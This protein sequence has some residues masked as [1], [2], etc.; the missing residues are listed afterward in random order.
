MKGLKKACSTIL[1]IFLLMQL[2]AAGPVFAAVNPV[3]PAP[4]KLSVRAIHN[5]PPNDIQPPIGFN[6]KEGGASGYYADLGWDLLKSPN[7]TP[8]GLSKYINIYVQ[9]VTKPYKAAKTL[10]KRERDLPGDTVSLRM[11]NLNSGTI[12]FM[13]AKAYYTYLDGTT[14]YTSSESASSNTVKVLTDI[15]INAFSF[16][17]SQIK[18]E[19]DD[20]W[21]TGRRIDYKLYV[22]DN[23]SFANTM[24]I[25]ISKEQIGPNG[26]V[27]VNNTTGKLEYVHTVNDPAK[28]YYVK[29]EPDVSDSAL[30]MTPASS[31]VMV[32]SFILAKTTKMSETDAGTIWRLDWSPVITGLNNM[33]VEVSYQIDKYI[34]DVPIPMLMEDG[35]STFISIPPGGESN[36]YIIRANV[37]KDGKPLY[38]SN[39]KIM[40]DRIVV[41]D[42]EVSSYPPTPE[43]IDEVGDSHGGPPI[44]SYADKYDA[45][46]LLVKK[47]ELTSTSA[48]IMWRVPKKAD[49]QVDTDVTYDIWLLADPNQIDNP[50]AGTKVASSLKMSDS[51]KIMDGNQLA[52]YKYTVR[53]LTS[54][55]TYYFKIVAKKSYIEYIGNSLQNKE[56][57]S[58][59]ALKVIIT[60]TEGPIDQPKV[61]A[62]PPFK[63][64]AKDSI[65]KTEV[66]IQL[67]NKWYE[68]FNT[69]SGKWEYIRTEKLNAADTPPY[70]PSPGTLD[71]MKYRV[72]EYDPGVTIDVGCIKFTDGMSLSDLSI[73]PAN[74]V[75]NFPVAANDPDEDPTLNAPEQYNTTIFKKHNIDIKI[76]DLEPNTTYI[77]WVRASRESINLTSGPSDPIIITTNPDV[78]PLVEKPVVPLFN[79]NRV[80]DTYVDLG[81][82][83]KPNYNYYIKYGTEDKINSASSSIAIKPADLAFVSYYKVNGLKSN[84]LYYFWIQAEATNGIQS[85]KSEWS[86]SYPLKTLPNIPPSSPRGFGVKNA[87]GAITKNSITFEWLKEN[88][89]EYILEVSSDTAYKDVK[90]YKPG[91]VSEFTVNSLRSNYR[92]FARLYAFD[93]VKNIKSEPTA[94]ITVRT[95]RS[96]DDY[97]S[98]QDIENVISGDY[99]IKDPTVVKNIWNVKI[100][101]VNADRFINHVQTDNMLDYR[102]DLTKPPSAAGKISISIS[103][104]VFEALSKLKEN[105]IIMTSTSQLVIRPDVLVPSSMNIPV[106]A[107]KDF[108]YEIVISYPDTAA[109]TNMKNMSFKTQVTGIAISAYDGG[110]AKPVTQLVK[111]L[112]IV[113]PFTG[114]NWYKEG[115]TSG[116]EY[117]PGPDEWNKLN[118]QHSFNSDMNTGYLNFDLMKPGKVA[119]ADVGSDYFDDI[120]GNKY[121]ASI[122]NVASAIKLKNIS[123]RLFEPDKYTTISD[124]VKFML[125][126]LGEDYNGYME[127]AFRAGLIS[128]NDISRPGDICTR[129]K[130][131]NMVVGAYELK[132]GIGKVGS[133]IEFA[134]NNGIADMD[135][136]GIAALKE[137]LTR[138]ELMSML[139][140]VLALIG[141]ID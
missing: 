86:D 17:T 65:G 58:Q 54:N 34:N 75:M 42:Q 104:R 72:V 16:G 36:Y 41:K 59:P 133:R 29:V 124:A 1:V 70:I 88:G 22:S 64:K 136:T 4:E 66:T 37:T 21:D 50:P 39:I 14:T 20:V 9:E 68:K 31:T 101:G 51:N 67:K 77:I 113:I 115:I 90:E 33:G 30:Q 26:P 87:D 25:Y 134:V 2:D 125:D 129:E 85:V 57:L 32:S 114:S 81:W 110:N 100:I 93:P 76:T 46:G 95:E 107:A 38:P 79:Y 111:P 123:G 61:P 112:K 63:V 84:T 6:D 126:F 82:G 102:L 128:Y 45:N 47:G 130:A 98:D 89:I 127:K 10:E 7:P 122:N 116:Y 140:K 8:A 83:F 62:K 109:N 56:Y 52:G 121:E 15:A 108:N 48:T 94:S 44:I 96:S 43:L 35:T 24:P 74:K 132:P 5:N 119:V 99:I 120:Y 23:S 60:P 138:G 80:G 78:P 131:I 135:K 105:L 11:M 73:L 91:A 12:Y 27:V 141:D 118:T 69:T 97:D 13:S 106:T 92:Y 3:Q 71:N 40:S 117:D 19:W 18:I 103:S 53:N 137:A 55:S 49:G 139:E 28:V